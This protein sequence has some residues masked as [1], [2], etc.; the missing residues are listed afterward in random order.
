METRTYYD[1]FHIHYAGE[2]D[3]EV[4]GINPSWVSDNVSVV[5]YLLAQSLPLVW[6][7]IPVGNANE[8]EAP[9]ELQT[10]IKI[11]FNRENLIS[12]S[13]KAWHQPCST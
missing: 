9:K 13:S 8:E 5:F 7:H 11:K 1:Y 4:D 12:V 10:D 2:E 3:K 6:I